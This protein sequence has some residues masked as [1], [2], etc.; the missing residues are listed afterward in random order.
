MRDYFYILI[1]FVLLVGTVGYL[2]ASDISNC[3]ERG[4][5]YEACNRAFNR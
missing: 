2:N 1:F 5:T 3:M 4:H